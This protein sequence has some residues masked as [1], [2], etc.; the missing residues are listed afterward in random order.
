MDPLQ[1]R[2]GLGM[3]AIDLVDHDDDPEPD[4]ERLAQHEPGL[5]HRAFG[6]IN[7]QQASIGHVEDTLDFPAE[8][9]MPGGVDDVD[10]HVAVPDRRV[11][12]QDRDALLTLEVVRVHDQRTDLLVLAEGVALLQKR[13]DERRLAM[14]DV[15]DDRHVPDVMTDLGHWTWQ[16]TG[17]RC[18]PEPFLPSSRRSG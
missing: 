15:G 8:V 11:L 16:Y 6:R 9:R 2:L 12:G 3:S 4:L 1:R 13:V 17:C 10:G 5:R 7:Q 14:V 18:A